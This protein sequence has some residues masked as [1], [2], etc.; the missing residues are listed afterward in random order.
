MDIDALVERIMARIE[1]DRA[2][3]KS[4]IAEEIQKAM[5]P[6]WN[7]PQPVMMIVDWQKDAMQRS[8]ERFFPS[9]CQSN[10]D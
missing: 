4:S 1:E 2:I 10:F 9:T 6:T 8:A 5:S 7:H 3:H